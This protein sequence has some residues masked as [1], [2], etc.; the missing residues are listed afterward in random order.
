[1][2][3]L[4]F[5]PFAVCVERISCF[6]Y[7]Q[8]CILLNRVYC[9]GHIGYVSTART[10]FESKNVEWIDAAATAQSCPH[11]IQWNGIDD[12]PYMWRTGGLKLKWPNRWLIWMLRTT[13]QPIKINIFLALRED[14]RGSCQLLIIMKNGRSTKMEQTIFFVLLRLELTRVKIL[15]QFLNQQ[16]NGLRKKR[17]RTR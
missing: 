16:L 8:I 6:D 14:E 13:R 15:L 9:F 1:M 12:E 3:F 11:N 2:C 7:D 10:R 5:C 4:P 17:G